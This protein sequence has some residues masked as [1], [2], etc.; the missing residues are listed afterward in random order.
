MIVSALNRVL[1]VIPPPMKTLFTALAL[2]C[3]ALLTTTA[4]HAQP[5]S[6]L[7][8]FAKA[9]TFGNFKAGD[10]FSLKIT[11]VTIL[12]SDKKPPKGAP[13]KWKK[14]NKIKFTITKKGEISAAGMKPVPYLSVDGAGL[15]MFRKSKSPYDLISTVRMAKLPGKKV[16]KGDAVFQLVNIT[17]DPGN[18]TITFTF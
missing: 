17:T 2:A 18:R 15:H 8:D 13:T 1:P 7:A 12:S 16:T 14:G 11:N 6:Q 3:G 4:A 9:K 5:S 10:T